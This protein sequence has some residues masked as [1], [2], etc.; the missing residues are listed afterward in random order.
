MYYESFLFLIDVKIID[1][2]G[3]WMFIIFM[4]IIR[5]CV[6]EVCVGEDRLLFFIL[7]SWCK[8]LYIMLEMV[9]KNVIGDLKCFEGIKEW[10]S[11]F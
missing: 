5:W 2:F 6:N 1:F 11:F 9:D 4:L 10:L 3:L 8:L 7:D